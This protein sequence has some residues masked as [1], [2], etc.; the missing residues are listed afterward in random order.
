VARHRLVLI[1]GLP[2]TG[3]TPTARALHA[4]LRERGVDCAV[5]VEASEDNP[6]AI[7]S[8]ATDLGDVIAR[9]PARTGAL[10]DWEALGRSAPGGVTILESRFIQNAAMFLVL[11]GASFDEAARLTTAIAGAIRRLDP[12][13]VY[14]RPDDPRAHIERVLREEAT[15]WVDRV[16]SVWERSVWARQRGLAGR[17]AFV[18]FFAE[19]APYLDVLADGSAFET[20]RIADP[21][22]N[23]AQA[24]PRLADALA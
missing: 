13:L 6:I 18:R 10:A 4:A 8:I 23:W 20:F 9:Y 21:R 19:W 1:E 17:E 16:T 14:L 24:I 11:G 2:G 7:G 15:G 5:Y 3:K 12:L 22:S